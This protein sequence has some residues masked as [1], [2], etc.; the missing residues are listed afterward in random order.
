MYIYVCDLLNGKQRI[1]MCDLIHIE[2]LPLLYE[3]INSI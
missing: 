1:K 2:D 3:V